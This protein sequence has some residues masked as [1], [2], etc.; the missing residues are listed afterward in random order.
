MN[1]KE[2]YIHELMEKHSITEEAAY[3]LYLHEK[4]LETELQDKQE[5]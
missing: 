2:K 4:E 3:A 5:Q 1:Q